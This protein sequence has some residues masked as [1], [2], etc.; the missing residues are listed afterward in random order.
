MYI[1]QHFAEDRTET[2]TEFVRSNPFCTLVTNGPEGLMASHIPLLFDSGGGPNGTLRGHLAKANPQW[3]T[4]A[5]DS[6]VLAI[7]NGPH[8]YISPSWYPS[9]TEHGRVVPTWNY[10]AVHAYG[11]IRIVEDRDSLLHHLRKL[12]DSQEEGIPGRWRIDDAP[13]DYI[14]GMTSAIVGVEIEVTKLEGKWKVSQNRPAADR[15][16]VVARLRDLGGD[17]AVAIAALIEKPKGS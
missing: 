11:Q 5:Q 15:E 7:F 8:H 3:R 13:P 16:A 4:Y 6:D 14:D 12:T 2:L 1:P 17:A 10:V 9:K